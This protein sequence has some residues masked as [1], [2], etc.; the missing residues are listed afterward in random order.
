MI[1]NV[2]WNRILPNISCSAPFSIHRIATRYR[3]QF[4]GLSLY[5]EIGK[6]AIED[7]EKET[8]K[9]KMLEQNYISKV[10]KSV[11]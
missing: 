9:H 1:V 3:F 11:D 8:S 2:V 6:T 7:L 10:P 5:Q 4:Y